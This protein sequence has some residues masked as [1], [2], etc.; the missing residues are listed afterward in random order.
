MA[1]I[2]KNKELY[3]ERNIKRGVSKEELG[4]SY[5]SFWYY[6]VKVVLCPQRPYVYKEET[7]NK[8]E[9]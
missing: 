6:K 8:K 3:Y 2:L 4:L 9:E 7:A 1:K 5:L